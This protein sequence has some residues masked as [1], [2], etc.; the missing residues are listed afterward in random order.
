[1]GTITASCH[2]QISVEWAM[3]GESTITVKA[4]TRDAHRASSY[5]SVCPAC[6]KWYKREGLILKTE[7]QKQDWYKYGNRKP[8]KP[9][10]KRQAV[11]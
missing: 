5:M 11:T 6:L 10:R 4:Y 7:K 3:G 9:L 8:K 1:M 2:H